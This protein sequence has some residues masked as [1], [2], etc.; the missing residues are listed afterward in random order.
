MNE[1]RI[2]ERLKEKD[3]SALEELMQE[4]ENYIY[5]IVSRILRPYMSDEDVQEVVNDVFYNIWK[6]VDHIDL[7]KGTLKS[8]LIVSARNAAK[9]KFRD[10]KK[11]LPLQEYDE[12]EVPDSFEQLDYE[13]KNLILE[14]ALSK[15]KPE[16]RNIIIRYYFLYQNTSEIAKILNLSTNTVKSKMRRARK[17]MEKY[18][19]ERGV[20]E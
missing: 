14:E 15:L 4:Y 19:R 16:E 18:L 12:I 20:H 8:Y 7:D 2:L 1:I 9:N 17:K 11:E 13:E 10:Y 3:P 6:H 5:Q